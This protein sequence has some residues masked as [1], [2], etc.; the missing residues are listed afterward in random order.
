MGY[1]GDSAG[2]YDRLQIK[3]TGAVVV[4]HGNFQS[5]GISY[6]LNEG[7]RT[8][9]SAT[10]SDE[11]EWSQVTKSGITATRKSTKKTKDQFLS[12]YGSDISF[13]TL[14]SANVTTELG[15]FGMQ[16]DGLGGSDGTFI[17][18]SWKGADTTRYVGDSAGDYDRLQIKSTGAVVV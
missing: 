9:E 6:P 18:K 5:I 4:P 2:D 13:Q 3:S 11:T 16:H 7:V 12:G 10:V 14:D 17:F 8:K 1:V 15:I